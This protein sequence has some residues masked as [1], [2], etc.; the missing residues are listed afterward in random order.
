MV[1]ASRPADVITVYEALQSLGKAADVGGLPYLNSLAQYVPSVANIRR[2]AE[3]VRERSILRKLVS[4]SD[5]IA[6]SAFNAKSSLSFPTASI[7]RLDE[8]RGSPVRSLT[9][10]D[11]AQ[12]P[13]RLLGSDELGVI[14]GSRAAKPISVS[15][16]SG[17][18]CRSSCR[19]RSSTTASSCSAPRGTSLPRKEVNR[20]RAARAVCV[21]DDRLHI[22]LQSELLRNSPAL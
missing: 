13:G 20:A 14:P 9:A 1:N 2:Y 3:V 21:A 17:L 7:Q 5:E 22:R 12:G 4:A 10:A 11:H 18:R 19:S 16:R 6:T 8:C 15:R